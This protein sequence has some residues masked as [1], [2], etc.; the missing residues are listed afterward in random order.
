MDLSFFP[1]ILHVNNLFNLIALLNTIK[2]S[3]IK[4][5]YFKYRIHINSIQ[6]LLLLIIFI[7]ISI[8]IVKF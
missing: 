3:H 8:Y 4:Q 1:G 7:G 5:S 6:N 2:T